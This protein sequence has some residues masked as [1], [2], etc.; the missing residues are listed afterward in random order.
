MNWVD[1]VRAALSAVAD[2][3]RALPMAAYMKGIA[4][5]LGVPAPA[6]RA[7]IRGLGQPP[8]D[9]LPGVVMEL[10]R[11]PEREFAYVAVDWLERASRK[12]PATLLP[13]IEVL[14]RN[15]SWWDTVDSLSACA[16]NLIVAHPELAGEMDR[17]VADPDIWIARVAILH[18]LGRGAKTDEG[19]LFR[20]CLARA[21]ER[22]FFIRKAIGW[23]LR[24][25]AWRNPDAVDTFVSAHRDDL[26]ALTIREATKN[27][28]NARAAPRR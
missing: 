14:V 10:W 12:G 25:Y 11:Q 2:P 9:E 16:A 20:L 5:F 17:W 6:R 22:E 27:L 21:D 13:L 8:I 28:T 7:A 3:A 15:R 18:Q 4:P 24:D 1:E 26:S 23:A 19:R